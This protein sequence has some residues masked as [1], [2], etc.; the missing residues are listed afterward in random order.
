MVGEMKT[1]DNFLCG[2]IPTEN[3]IYKCNKIFALIKSVQSKD[4]YC[5]LFKEKINV[6]W[7]R[8]E[9]VKRTFW[10]ILKKKKKVFVEINEILNFSF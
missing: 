10:I 2:P 5:R 6:K 8:K 1:L 3:D 4:I 7:S 9:K